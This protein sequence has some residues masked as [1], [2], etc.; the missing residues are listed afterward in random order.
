MGDPDARREVDEI[1]QTLAG[2]HKMVDERLFQRRYRLPIFLAIAIGLF[3]QLS[4]ST[5]LRWRI[6]HLISVRDDP[7]QQGDPF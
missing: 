7:S 2:Q 6:R 3:N 4:G 1:A 5:P